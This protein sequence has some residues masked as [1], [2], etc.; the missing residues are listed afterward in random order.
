MIPLR[1][2]VAS[3]FQPAIDAIVNAVREQQQAAP[4]TSR[5]K[6]RVSQV[7]SM[8]MQLI[9]RR[10]YC[11]SAALLP[12]RGSSRGFRAR[13]TAWA[14]IFRARIGTRALISCLHVKITPSRLTCDH[15]L[16]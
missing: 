14:S 9:K 2:N 3:F 13:R 10:W 6:V 5:P 11:L 7:A 15:A 4:D 12:V 8:R 1:D 16:Q